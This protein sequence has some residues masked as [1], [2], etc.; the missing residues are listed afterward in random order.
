VIGTPLVVGP[1]EKSALQQLR[2]L[3]AQKPVNMD[4]LLERLQD[5]AKKRRH[6]QQM[7]AQTIPI[8]FAYTVTFSIEIGHPGG[9]TARHM[10]MSV[11]RDGRLP[12]PEAV[13]MICE[14]LGF[15]GSLQQ[16][17][18]VFIERLSDGGDAVNVVQVISAPEAGR[19]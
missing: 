7:T 18:A 19:A 1:D 16:C 6:M 10:S 15:I 2:E 8:P 17:D 13:W 3:A 11:L 14:Q 4:G 12:R 9:A 5:P